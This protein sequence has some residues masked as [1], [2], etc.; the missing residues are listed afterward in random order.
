MEYNLLLSPLHYM[1]QWN[2][3]L[4]TNRNKGLNYLKI[5]QN[6]DIEKLTALQTKTCM[7]NSSKEQQGPTHVLSSHH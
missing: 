7:V 1:N 5:V 2:C 6:S 4:W 3:L